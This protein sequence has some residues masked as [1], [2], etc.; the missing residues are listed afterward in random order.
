MGV[1]ERRVTLKSIA[2]IERMAIAGR[3]VAEV[4]DR[5]GEA[6]RP[7]VTTGELDKLATDLIRAAGATPSFVGR[8]P[9]ACSMAIV[10]V[11][12]RSSTDPLAMT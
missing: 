8:T 5:V 6:I 4:L 2:Q 7:G 11:S 12:S 9:V 3:L 1:R 10:A